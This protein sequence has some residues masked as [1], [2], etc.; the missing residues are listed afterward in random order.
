MKELVFVFEGAQASQNGKTLPMTGSIY[1][2]NI[3]VVTGTTPNTLLID[4]FNDRVGTCSLGGSRADMADT[5]TVTGTL[6]GTELVS[7]YNNVTSWGGHTMLLGGGADSWQPV[8]RSEL[9]QYNG[10]NITSRVISG[11]PRVKIE[12]EVHSPYLASS[13]FS[14]ETRMFYY[15]NGQNATVN[16][17]NFQI[18]TPIGVFP[19]T[20]LGGSFRTA[21]DIIYGKCSIIYESASGYTNSGSIAINNIQLTK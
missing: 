2:D 5:G 11:T 4:N 9:M 3:R 14:P 19:V 7:T 12:F 17:N 18:A 10:I 16:F 8:T 15:F 21:V 6:N 20:D 1:V 13:G